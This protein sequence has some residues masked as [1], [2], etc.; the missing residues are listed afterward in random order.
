MSRRDTHS[1]T[2][3]RSRSPSHSHSRSLSNASMSSRTPS[4]SLPHASIRPASARSERK[5]ALRIEHLTHNVHEAHLHHIVGWY[6]RIVRVHLTLSQGSQRNG[7]AC[8]EMASVEEA[9]KAALYLRGGQIDGASLSVNT[10][11][12]PE[13]L[14]STERRR[15]EG[16]WNGGRAG[17]EVSGVHPDRQRAIGRA[18]RYGRGRDVDGYARPMRRWGQPA[19]RRGRDR[20]VSPGPSRSS[21]AGRASPSY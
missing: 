5:T 1:R 6:G 17:R 11:T 4:P 12:P 10:C 9:A 14:A 18:E 2:R 13:E 20:S 16:R 8:V 3:T 15:D 21:G 19:E 7:W